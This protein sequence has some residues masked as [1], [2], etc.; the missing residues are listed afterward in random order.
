M[1]GPVILITGGGSGI[2][3]ASALRLARDH[4]RLVLIDRDAAGAAATAR[5]VVAAGGEALTLCGD[6]ANPAL[7]EQ[8]AALALSSFGRI[9]GLVTAA[10]FS[11]GGTVLTTSPDD[12]DAV[13]AANVKGTFLFAKAVIPAMQQQSGGAIVTFA[14]QLAIAGGKGN[15]AYVAAKGAV[16]SLTRTMAVD[17]AA[18]GI[19]VNAV[20]PGAVET[21]MLARSFARAADP[22]AARAT[23]AA[24]HAMKRL[25]QPDEVA[26][27]VAFLLSPAASFVTGVTLPVD[28]GWLA[29]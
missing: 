24:R 25:G 14:S 16:M 7:S 21:P 15:A 10:G 3:Q 19:R 5:A 26:E 9:D 11:V 6:V 8:A 27:A 20:A 12:W 2:G 22:E 13:F 28:G 17:F 4:A 18:D 1:S 29:A 23:S